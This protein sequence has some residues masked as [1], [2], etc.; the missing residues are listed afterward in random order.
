MFDWSDSLL[1]STVINEDRNRLVVEQLVVDQDGARKSRSV[2]K[3]TFSKLEFL[4]NFCELAV[5]SFMITSE[6]TEV[7]NFPGL[8]GRAF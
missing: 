8:G 3:H 5:A 1:C 6:C 4:R 7:I 2:C